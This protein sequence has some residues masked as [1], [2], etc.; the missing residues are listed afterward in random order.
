MLDMVLGGASFNA[1][2]MGRVRKT[3]MK[4]RTVMN[5]ELGNGKSRY[6]SSEVREDDS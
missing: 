6:E 3:K 1:A 5:H 4:I 2:A